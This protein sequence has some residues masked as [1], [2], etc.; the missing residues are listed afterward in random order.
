[1][2]KPYIHSL[3]SVKKYGGKWQDYIELHSFMDLSKSAVADN[4]HRVQ[5]HNAFFIGTIAERVKFSNSCDPTGDNRFPT[6][7]NSDGKHVS[8][9]DIFEDHVLEDFKMRFIPTLQDYV[10]GM[11]FKDWMNNGCG[12]PP[13]F[14][15]INEHRKKKLQPEIKGCDMV[16]DGSAV[17]QQERDR[18]MREEL[19]KLKD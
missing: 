7:I 16:L 4:R 5:T 8:V 15:K 3:N 6:I 9:R 17:R 13:S 11:E 19:S 12:A 2:S 10:E 1:M 14:A 18:Q